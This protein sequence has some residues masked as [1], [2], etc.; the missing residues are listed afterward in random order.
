LIDVLDHLGAGRLLPER[1]RQ[2]P[3]QHQSI[4]RSVARDRDGAGDILRFT[5]VLLGEA[6]ALAVLPPPKGEIIVGAAMN[7]FGFKSLHDAPGMLVQ[8]FRA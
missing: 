7:S 3:I 5:E 4:I 6:A 8:Y 1:L 2:A